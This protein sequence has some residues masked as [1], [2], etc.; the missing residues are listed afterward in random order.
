MQMANSNMAAP[1]APVSIMPADFSQIMNMQAAQPLFNA[2]APTTPN[3]FQMPMMQ[4]QPQAQLM[5]N[6]VNDT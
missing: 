5:A 2:Q 4:P 3:A 6:M 1:V